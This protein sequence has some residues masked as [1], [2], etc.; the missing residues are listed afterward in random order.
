MGQ[1]NF[2]FIIFVTAEINKKLMTKKMELSQGAGLG[3]NTNCDLIS[4]LTQL[5][6]IRGK[7]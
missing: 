2:H 1:F 3:V 4:L 5:G 7:S 6:I